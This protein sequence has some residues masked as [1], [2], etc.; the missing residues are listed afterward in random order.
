MQRRL[1]LAPIGL[2]LLGLWLALFA[3][4]LGWLATVPFS[5]ANYRLNLVLLVGV[6]GLV[7]GR[8]RRDEPRPVLRRTPRRSLAAAGLALGCAAAYVAVDHGLRLHTLAA[9]L[10]GLGSYGLLGLFLEAAAWRAA[11]GSA[12]LFIAVLP[13]G[14]HGNSYL[15]LGV[16]LVCAHAVQAAL[17]GLSIGAVSA[18][19]ILVLENGIAHID[20]PCSGLR[21]LWAGGLFYLLATWALRR[22]TG[23]RWALGGLLLGGLLV[24]ANTARVLA[25]V[26][27][28]LHLKLHG[29]GEVLHLPLGVIGFLFACGAALLYLYA[30]PAQ[31]PL[32]SGPEAPVAAPAPRWLV[33]GL[34]AGL[35]VLTAVHA[36][37][38][39]D[40][41]PHRHPRITLPAEL[42]P[43]SVPLDEGEVSL[44]SR[45]GARAEKWRIADPRG[46]LGGSLL[47]VSASSVR[48]Q[49]P[50]ELCLVAHGLKIQSVQTVELL[51]G[52]PMRLLQ[53][54]APAPPSSNGGDGGRYTAV[55]WFQAREKTVDSFL[56][57]IGVTLLGRERR[58]VLVSL[59]LDRRVAPD[60]PAL[61]SLVA[62]LH[63][64]IAQTLAREVSP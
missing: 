11:L 47:M 12:L 33:A 43:R 14:A 31:P 6:A 40:L 38:P 59:L 58:W 22:Q 15:G 36:R 49:H 29:V 10:F 1:T 51:P 62:A 16:R 30:L 32:A 37:R 46:R 61:Q 13:F 52:A 41:D 4:L 9:I 57:R 19:T 23:L 34:A 3:P 45:F 60:D 17:S 21:S 44:F 5:H 39:A 25:L 27:L 54:Q 24:L 48:A 53:T 28:E 56:G 50:P 18:Q 64:A 8:W 7:L 42:A 63:Q 2:V 55:N 20:V 35:L 26:V